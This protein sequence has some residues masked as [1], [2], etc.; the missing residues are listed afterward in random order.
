MLRRHGGKVKY[1]HSEPGLNSR[2]DE[3]QAAVLRIKL[4]YLDGWT[5]ARRQAA[6]RYNELMSGLPAVITPIGDSD[7][8]R[9][10]AAF[11]QYTIRSSIRDRIQ[12]NL[13]KNGIGCC[14]YYPVPLHLQQVYKSLGYGPGDFPSAELAA[15]ECLS[16]PMFP[17]LT[18]EQQRRVAS[19]VR[20]IV[21]ELPTTRVA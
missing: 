9:T 4:R 3:I 15:A 10:F 7:P 5:M 12:F 13:T 21:A 11:A 14:I 17:E 6:Q 16:L 18:W 8:N 20:H 2:L 1:H 19:E